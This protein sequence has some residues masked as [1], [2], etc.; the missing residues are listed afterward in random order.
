VGGTKTQ[1]GPVSR[2]SAHLEPKGK[3]EGHMGGGVYEV[4]KINS[5]KGRKGKR[6]SIYFR[7]NENLT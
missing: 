3:K 4:E 5:R 2:K 6:D 7:G 1:N